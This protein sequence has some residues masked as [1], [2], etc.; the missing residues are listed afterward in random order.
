LRSSS[1]AELNFSEHLNLISE[2]MMDSWSSMDDVVPNMEDYAN[3]S[4]TRITV[5]SKD[6]SVLKYVPCEPSV[7][8]GA[9]VAMNNSGVAFN[10]LA[11]TKELSRVVGLVEKKHGNTLC[12]I[13]ISNT[14]TLSF[15]GLN[16]DD[17]YW[18]SNTVPGGRTTTPP[19]TIGQFKVSLGYALGSDRFVVSLSGRQQ[20]SG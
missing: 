1:I 10:A 12:D 7:Y 9:F 3:P 13:R 19:N 14:S 2:T 17:D 16:G 8:V 18:L 5:T 4:T 6:L 15:S 11:T 20:I